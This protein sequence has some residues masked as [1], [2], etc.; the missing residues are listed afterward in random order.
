MSAKRDGKH[1]KIS[2]EDLELMLRCAGGKRQ[3]ELVARPAAVEGPLDE[4][5]G[6]ES[7]SGFSGEE[8]SMPRGDCG[9]L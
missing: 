6:I 5:T 7:W 2:G 3:V 1:L 9:Y 8:F 4:A